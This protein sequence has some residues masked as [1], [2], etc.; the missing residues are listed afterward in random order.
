MEAALRAAD[1]A[2]EEATTAI[3]GP[4]V[5]ARI[6][7]AAAAVAA[8]TP[9]S[10]TAT[11]AGPAGLPAVAAAA[12]V[13]LEPLESDGEPAIIN[14]SAADRPLKR[15]RKLNVGTKSAQKKRCLGYVDL[16]EG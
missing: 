11:D 2:I 3:G 9:L 12:A 4:E 8:T 13:K 1:V 6:L 7:A 5:V 10:I 16:T 15:K 14:L